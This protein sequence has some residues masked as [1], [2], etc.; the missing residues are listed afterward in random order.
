MLKTYSPVSREF[1][2]CLSYFLN[3]SSSVLWYLLNQYSRKYRFELDKYRKD[4]KYGKA[5]QAQVSEKAQA[6]LSWYDFEFTA[7]QNDTGFLIGKRDINIHEGYIEPI[8]RLRQPFKVKGGSEVN[9]PVDWSSLRTFF[10]EKDKT[11]VLQLCSRHLDK[12]KSFVDRAHERF[13]L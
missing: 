9:L 10:P 12:L 3:S 6:F 11:D 13:P 5:H 1:Q 4:E 8:Y 7:L 2:F